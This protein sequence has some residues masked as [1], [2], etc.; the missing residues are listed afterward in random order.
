M[1]ASFVARLV[2]AASVAHVLSAP[3]AIHGV[4][5]RD[6]TSPVARDSDLIGSD[7]YGIAPL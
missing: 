1:Y 5:D 4:V 7:Y 2:L 3:L 6:T